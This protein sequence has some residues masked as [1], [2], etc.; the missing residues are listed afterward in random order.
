MSRTVFVGNL[1]LDIRQRE[2]EDLFGKYG[3]LEDIDL[4]LPSRPPG[5][6]FIE[7]SDARDASDAVKGRDGYDLGGVR[8]RVRAFSRHVGTC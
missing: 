7:F 3:R 5:F 1:P 8:L 6:A 4:K 2:V